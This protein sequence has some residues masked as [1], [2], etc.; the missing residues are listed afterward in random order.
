MYNIKQKYQFE[1]CLTCGLMTQIES[2]YACVRNEIS[3]CR[4]GVIIIVSPSII[5]ILKLSSNYTVLC[6]LTEISFEYPEW[7]IFLFKWFCKYGTN[8][9]FNYDTFCNTHNINKIDGSRWCLF[10]F[11]KYIT[12]TLTVLLDIMTNR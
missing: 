11:V 3:K 10:I 7:H 9:R 6:T 8:D 5:Q 1:S 12:L 4:G 2:Y